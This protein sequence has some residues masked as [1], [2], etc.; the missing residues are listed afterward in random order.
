MCSWWRSPFGI[1]AA[2][3]TPQ[4]RDYLSDE[5]FGG[6]VLCVGGW[7][8]GQNMDMWAGHL[9]G[10]TGLQPWLVVFPP[11][12]RSMVVCNWWIPNK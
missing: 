8:N 9:Q 11:D 1:P 5:G 7:G 4:P 10:L 3:R 12:I 2:I 6:W